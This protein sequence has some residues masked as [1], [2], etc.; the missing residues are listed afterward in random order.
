VTLRTYMNL[1]GGAALPP[2]RPE[3]INF[4]R[5][6]GG[7]VRFSEPT[8]FLRIFPP[9]PGPGVYVIAVRDDQWSPRKYRPIYFG[10]SIDLASR[11][12]SSHENY[13]EWCRVA[14]GAAHLYVALHFMPGTTDSE[15]ATLEKSLI[16]R[17]QPECNKTSK[18][19][20]AFR[21]SLL[22][23]RPTAYGRLADLL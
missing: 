5:Q 14:G 6:E 23:T 20:E 9:P 19:G 4:Y 18:L 17:Y 10:K 22:Q 3:G 11:P 15:R 7:L 8:G 1:M 16:G 13:A 12:T 21:R 2:P